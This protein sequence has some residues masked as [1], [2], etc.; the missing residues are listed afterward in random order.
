[1]SYRDPSS[2]RTVDTSSATLLAAVTGATE[3][4]SNR[5]KL[6]KDF[7]NAAAQREEDNRAAL[8]KTKGVD[9]KTPLEG[10]QAEI[11]REVDELY[12]LDIASFE[13]DR[14]EF[15]KKQR[16]MQS[17]LESL[18]KIVGSLNEEAKTYNDKSMQGDAGTNFLRSNDPKFVN[19]VKDIDST[20]GKNLN[21]ILRDGNIIIADNQGN[22]LIN[23]SAYVRSKEQ[24]FDLVNYTDDYSKELNAADVNA[25]KGLDNLKLVETITKDVADGKKISKEKYTDYTNAKAEYRRRLEEGI[26]IDPIINEST[27]QTFVK[28]SQDAYDGSDAQKDA[29][30][31][32]MID[33]L[34]K[35]RFP[36][37]DRILQAVATADKE[38]GKATKTPGEKIDFTLIEQIQEDSKDAAL[39]NVKP[40]NIDTKA[41]AALVKD[42]K[43]KEIKIG[44]TRYQIYDFQ[45]ERKD[46]GKL[47]FQP[48]IIDMR[49]KK[50]TGAPVTYDVDKM[51]DFE[52]DLIQ[53]DKETSNVIEVESKNDIA[54][55][56]NGTTFIFN[57]KKYNKVSGN[58]A[59]N[60][61]IKEVN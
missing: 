11:E 13:G 20:G 33:H 38:K 30:R 60:T 21:F 59:A 35:Q 29:T 61:K 23:G 43:N 3:V 57:N 28:D 41:R 49:T 39:N 53:G 22:D 19:I 54:S 4:I 51:D 52:R 17:Y 47:S 15:I 50:P 46:D 12:K 56:D 2:G 31:Q 7:E 40:E 27:F 8:E 1:M 45:V 25:A 55:L 44:E 9:D 18:P 5:I 32:N 24:G 34:V 10:L 37:E 36:G 42:F 14:S 6:V 16:Q 58:T 26:L 48:I